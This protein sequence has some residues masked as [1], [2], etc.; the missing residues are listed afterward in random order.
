MSHLDDET[1]QRVAGCRSDFEMAAFLGIEIDG[2]P[3]LTRLDAGALDPGSKNADAKAHRAEMITSVRGGKHMELSI[4]ALTF[5]QRPT[6]N[7]RYLRLAADKLADRAGTWKNQPFLTDHNTYSMSAA[8]GTILSSKM[9]EESAKVSALEQVLHVV[10]PDAVIGFLDGTYRKFSIGWFA[11]GPVM[12]SVHGTDV[13]ASDGCSCWPGDTV[14]LDGKP[15]IVEYEFSDYEGKEVSAVVIPA[16]R[17]TSVSDI[18]AAL[19]AELQLPTRSRPPK[20]RTMPFPRLAAALALSALADTD[21]DRAVEAVTALR[22]RASAAELEAGTLRVEVTRITGELAL[23]TALAASASA[24]ALDA[25]IADAYKAG[26][27]GYGKDAAGA[28]TPDELESLLRDFGKT[29]GR[30]KL[31]AKLSAMPAR[32]PVGQAPIVNTVTEPAKAVLSLVYSDA[33]IASV[34]EQLGVPVA[35][36]RTRLGLPAVAQVAGGAR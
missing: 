18:R 16:V 24:A 5:R 15:R 21:E 25:L 4:T 27:L 8:K 34:A 11:L 7:R 2:Y 36:V 23:Q 9:V 13:R 31:A 22:S 28:N 6:P 26:K 20:E 30:D 10:K 12:C 14:M 33:Q 1:L 29:A 35:E 17:D 32:I 3:G 19:T